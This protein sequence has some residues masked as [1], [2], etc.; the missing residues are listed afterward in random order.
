MIALFNTKILERQRVK[1]FE[2]T[3]LRLHNKDSEVW[4]DC[5]Q[6]PII[7]E[8]PYTRVRN[9]GH[10]TWEKSKAK[11][12]LHYRT[13]SLKF[14]QA[15]R[16]YNC[17]RGLGINWIHPLCDGVDDLELAKE[18]R[19]YDTIWKNEYKDSEDQITDYFMMLNRE[20]IKKFRMLIISVIM[21]IMCLKEKTLRT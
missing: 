1:S 15:W 7:R 17:K 13:G 12:L 2:H 21:Y 4:F 8:R 6:S 19:F 11:A 16:L 20:R 10:F 14:K 3:N 9:K 18:C 5:H